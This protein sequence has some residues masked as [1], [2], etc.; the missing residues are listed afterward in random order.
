MK[1]DID[2]ETLREALRYDRETGVLYWRER[3][4][5]HFPKEENARSWNKRWAGKPALN[6]LLDGYRKG[7]FWGR[8]MSAHQAI[9]LMEYGKPAGSIDH[10]NGDRS[11]NRLSNLR[12]VTDLENQ[13]NTAIQRNNKSGVSGVCRAKNRW[14]V[15]I[16]CSYVGS[17]A[18]LEEAKEVRRAAEVE[19]GY[20]PN[21]DRAGPI[22][23]S[24]KIE[25]RKA[26]LKEI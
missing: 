3:P 2:P 24:R 9:W 23:P 5:H 17:Y 18:T 4:V 16:G 8:Y 6:S 13:R 22:Y 7:L 15:T 20:H 12:E 11:D 10:I 26:R 19:R 1:R 14:V 21:N 25:R